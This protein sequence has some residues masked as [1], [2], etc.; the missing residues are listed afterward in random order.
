MLTG[1]KGDPRLSRSDA[2]LELIIRRSP[3]DREDGIAV[4]TII[5]NTDHIGS[6]CTFAI[7]K[8][9]STVVALAQAS[10]GLTAAR[11]H[12]IVMAAA[13]EAAPII[14]C[15]VRRCAMPILPLQTAMPRSRR[16]LSTDSSGT[17]TGRCR[18]LLRRP[19][20]SRAYPGYVFYYLHS[21]LLEAGRAKL[22]DDVPRSGHGIRSRRR[23]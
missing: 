4:D 10:R 21:R 3:P 18:C 6:A 8:R 5:N 11:Q 17:R 2:V 7:G 1:L 13:D 16:R 12:I 20:V 19:P 9:K 23:S 15:R 22:A 14:S